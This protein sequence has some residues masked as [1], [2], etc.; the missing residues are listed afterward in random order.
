LESFGVD[1]DDSF[2]REGGFTNGARQEV[3]FKSFEEIKRYISEETENFSEMIEQINSRQF[4]ALRWF[5]Y[6]CEGLA[7]PVYLFDEPIE[8]VQEKK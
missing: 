8:M 7:P 3:G 2:N 6:I 5:Y 1:S 4:M